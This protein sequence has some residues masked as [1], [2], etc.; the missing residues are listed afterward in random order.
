[1]YIGKR[2]RELRM[3]QGMSLSGLAEKSGVQIATLSRI[4][5]L[6]MTGT[7]E[8]HMNIARALDIDITQL[9]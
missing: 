6:K 1:M 3:A 4:E 9:Y 2:L 8:S 7:V 5:H